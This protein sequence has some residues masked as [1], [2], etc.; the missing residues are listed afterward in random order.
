MSR[1]FAFVAA[2]LASNTFTPENKF[3]FSTTL[4]AKELTELT[5]GSTGPSATIVLP[6][7]T[8]WTNNI[9]GLEELAKGGHKVEVCVHVDG[10]V[11]RC[12]TLRQSV[13]WAGV[14]P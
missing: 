9:S 2:L 5:F 10:K 7:T 12:E 14:K 11:Q 8:T 6:W 3:T 4:T 13:P 1:V